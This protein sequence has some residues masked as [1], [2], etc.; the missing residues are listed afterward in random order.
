MSRAS[1]STR[2]RGP[3]SWPT[4][5]GCVPAPADVCLRTRAQV[6]APHSEEQT[7]TS[8]FYLP[9]APQIKT[10][11]AFQAIVRARAAPGNEDTLLTVGANEFEARQKSLS[12]PPLVM[13]AH[14]SHGGGG[15]QRFV[16]QPPRP[17]C[18]LPRLVARS[19]LRSAPLMPP[20]QTQPAVFRVSTQ[21]RQQSHPKTH[22]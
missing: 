19:S 12:V 1:P 15:G 18:R 3:T 13:S 7:P 17:T 22:A 10:K 8:Q 2:S 5:R 16:S 11:K 20:A 21:P 6:S 4:P 9:L 14:P